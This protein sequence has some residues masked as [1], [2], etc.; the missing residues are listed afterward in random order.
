MKT[1]YSFVFL[2]SALRVAVC[3]NYDVKN[4]PPELEKN[5]NAVV[6]L[7]EATFNIK[8]TS[9]ATYHVQEVITILN[10][11]GKEEAIKAV[12][13][14]K[15]IK[16]T[17]LKA[18]IYNANGTL[19]KRL[20]PNDFEDHSAISGF[21]LYEDNR[22]KVAD[23]SATQYPFTFEFEYEVEYK[24]LFQIPSFY[25]MRNE[26][27][28]VQNARYTV[29]YVEMAK[30]R[31]LLHNTRDAK[32]ETKEGPGSISWEYKDLKATIL[33]RYGPDWLELVPWIDIAPMNF[34]YDGYAG[35]MDSWKNF[36]LWI[37]MLNNERGELTVKTKM[38]V[39]KLTDNLPTNE[40]KVKAL[41]S[42]LQSKT[43]YV[44]IQL[45][46]GGF[47]PF[48]AKT[49][50]EVGYGDCKALSNYMVALLKEADIK[51]YY[52]LIRAGKNARPINTDFPSAEFNHVIVFVP[53]KSDTLWLEC[54]SQSN[55][56]NYLGSFTSDREALAITDEGGV[57]VKTPQIK[58]DNIQNRKMEIDMNADG[59]ASIICSTSFYGSQY[60]KKNLNYYVNLSESDQRKWLVSNTSLPAFKLDKFSLNNH[61]EEGPFAVVEFN[62]IS[63]R[64]GSASGK[65]LFI[66]PNVMGK[67][68][69][70]Y[71]SDDDR[72]TDIIIDETIIE[73]DTV[74]MK[75]PEN[76]YPEFIP[77]NKVISNQFGSYEST[78]IFSESGILYCRKFI[79]KKGV[80]SA[81]TYSL[82]SA[83]NKEVAKNDNIKLAFV[84][85]T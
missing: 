24:F 64:L 62:G 83:F 56:F 26:R 75:L 45:G 60:E 50:D 31:F 38:E 1:I 54:T 8:S 73:Y 34:E 76:F 17:T 39:Q 18:A 28:S 15:L 81:M 11:K 69:I 85:K 44:S 70:L 53:T 74:E 42:Y 52:T 10:P 49:V 29:T 61:V 32:A 80:Y 68:P 4:I 37:Q 13:Y 30:P 25:P 2:I 35:R 84:N 23:L 72:K 12:F 63:E 71:P 79:L 14:D 3:Q 20:K 9:N 19:L 41:Y 66:S 59:G 21:S 5:A 58:G 33:E 77:E 43:R 51:A 7:K 65:R 27:I 48:D 22:L 47:Q 78:F 16:V 46:I 82:L 6:R 55:P 40:E 57:I 36:G 67:L